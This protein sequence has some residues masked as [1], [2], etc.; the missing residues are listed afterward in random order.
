MDEIHERGL[1]V[2]IEE[3]LTERRTAR[4]EQNRPRFNA[5]R[6]HIEQQE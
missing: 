3:A 6:C 4:D 2:I 1:T 5:R